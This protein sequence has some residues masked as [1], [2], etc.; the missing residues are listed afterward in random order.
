MTELKRWYSICMT[1]SNT[2]THTHRESSPKRLALFTHPHFFLKRTFYH[3][4]LGIKTS[5]YK[6]FYFLSKGHIFHEHQ[7]AIKKNA[8]CTLCTFI[9]SE[10]ALTFK[11]YS[12]HTILCPFNCNY[13][14]LFRIAVFS[15]ADASEADSE[16]LLN[17]SEWQKLILINWKENG[18]WK[19]KEKRF[20]S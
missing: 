10:H 6:I 16:Q 15:S 2:H 20:V 11:T 19:S 4:E 18:L 12:R 14:S 7:W 9:L 1:K 17:A 8:V 13:V 5:R 3:S